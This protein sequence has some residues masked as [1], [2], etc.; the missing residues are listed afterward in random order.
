MFLVI[1]GYRIGDGCVTWANDVAAK[2]FSGNCNIAGNP[3]RMLR[4]KMKNINISV[5]ILHFESLNDTKGCLDSLSK[6]QNNCNINIIVVDNGSK[7]AK[8]QSIS[9]DYK[10]NPKVTF[11]YSDS[12]LGFAK[13]NNLGFKYAKDNY[14]PDI[15]ILANS[16]LLFSQN[17]F[18]ERLIIHYNKDKFDVAGPKIISLKDGKNQNPVGQVYHTVNE[19]RTRIIKLWILKLLSYFNLDTYFKKIFGK[20]IP[21]YKI[22]DGEDFQLHGACMLF[23][24]KYIDMFDGLYSGTFMYGEECILKYIITRENMR[25]YYYDDIEVFHKEGSS[26]ENFYGKG[27]KQRQFFYHWSI[28]SLMQLLDMMRRT[29]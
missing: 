13:G 24:K 8:L 17:D 12:N 10:N 4:E 18:F 11:L 26:T 19:V 21:E 25:M 6:Y 29:R 3:A 27:K 14:K 20:E 1:K 9:G 28:D 16:D 22:A 5:V 15:I 7:K 2:K 23:G